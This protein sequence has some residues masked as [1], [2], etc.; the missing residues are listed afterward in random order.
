[1][2]SV[3]VQDRANERVTDQLEHPATKSFPASW[4]FTQV[5]KMEE[6][7]LGEVV[8]ERVPSP[9]NTTQLRVAACELRRSSTGVQPSHAGLTT[10]YQSEGE[11]EDLFLDVPEPS[12]LPQPTVACQLGRV[13]V[14]DRRWMLTLLQRV[15]HETEVTEPHRVDYSVETSTMKE[16]SSLFGLAAKALP[17]LTRAVLQDVAFALLTVEDSKERPPAEVVEPSDCPHAYWRRHHHHHLFIKSIH[18][19]NVPPK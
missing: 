19:T 7:R 4:T 6:E 3:S 8:S 2:Q 1:M 15:F 17:A 16:Q 5:S 10:E 14:N 13:C 18:E 12:V 9:Q 11:E